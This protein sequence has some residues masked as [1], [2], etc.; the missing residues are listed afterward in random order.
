MKAFVFASIL[1]LAAALVAQQAGSAENPPSS[2]PQATPSQQAPAT[3]DAT[4]AAQVQQD[5]Q[6]AWQSESDLSKAKLSAQV[7]GGAIT[8]TGT[9][10]NE[11]QHQKAL[12]VAALHASGMRIV[13]KI[14]VQPQ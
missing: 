14:K 12:R 10:G 11:E 3:P 9:V 6:Q 1:M 7:S 5:I 4:A 8:L 2:P 13:D